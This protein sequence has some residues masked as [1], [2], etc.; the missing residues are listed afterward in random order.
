MRLRREDWLGNEIIF[1]NAA[2]LATG[3]TIGKNLGAEGF[4]GGIITIDGTGDNKTY[5]NV[6]KVVGAADTIT[7][8]LADDTTLVYTRATGELKTTT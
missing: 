5:I 6:V 7:L 4:V 1:K 3:I 8:T 2:A